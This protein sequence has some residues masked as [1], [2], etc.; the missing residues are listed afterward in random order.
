MLLADDENAVRYPPI[1]AWFFVVQ[2]A[3]VAGLHVV[4]MLPDSDA[5]RAAQLWASSRSPSPPA[6][7]ARSTG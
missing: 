3:A 2:A 5:G 1:P 4:R 6:A 7:A